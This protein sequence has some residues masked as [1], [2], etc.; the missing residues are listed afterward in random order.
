MPSR[1]ALGTAFLRAVHQV[2]D[3]PPRILEDP[4]AV[5][6]L[7]AGALR[8]ITEDPEA[9]QTPGRRGLRAHIVL[10][11]R[12]CEDQLEAAVS[13]G[14][15]Q[16]V[17]LGAGFDTFAW[18][19]PEWARALRIVE[20]D[21][22]ATQAEKR[23]RLQTAGL[24]VPD[25]LTFAAIDFERGTLREG[26]ARY[27]GLLDAPTFFSWLGVSMYLDEPAVDALLV[28]AGAFPAGSG[29]VL[30]FASPS[31]VPS[32]VEAAAASIGEPW[33][34]RFEPTHVEEK[35]HS[36]GFGQV[37]FLTRADADARY[38]AGRPRDLPVPRRTSIA[39]GVK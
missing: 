25:N 22:E 17:L 32:P 34:S 37:G 3:A 26:L 9:W 8:R 36:A 39:W 21:H 11:S 20:V 15:T 30:T 5:P 14:V 2:L 24:S 16:Y 38:F 31:D 13:R 4:L 29:I 28:S 35:L 23:A 19:Q 33:R 7:G 27:G 18:R 12:F 6:L 1:T 10:R